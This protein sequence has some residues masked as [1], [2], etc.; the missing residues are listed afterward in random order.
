MGQLEGLRRLNKELLKEDQAVLK[1]LRKNTEKELEL[2]FSA[3][4]C[5]AYKLH[6]VKPANSPKKKKI[7]PRT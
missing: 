6:Q 2:T 3:E 4:S 5:H 1:I 7:T